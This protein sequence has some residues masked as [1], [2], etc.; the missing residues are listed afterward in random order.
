MN[1]ERNIKHFIEGHI[2]QM[3][4]RWPQAYISTS[5]R[6]GSYDERKNDS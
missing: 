6:W 2:P 5:R 3:D 1:K 4:G